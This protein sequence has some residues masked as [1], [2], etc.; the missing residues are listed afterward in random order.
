MVRTETTTRDARR[1]RELAEDIRGVW[2]ILDRFV[3]AHEQRGDVDALERLMRALT[4][5]VNDA[6]PKPDVWTE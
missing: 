3:A 5:A 2:P 4:R 6:T 1:V